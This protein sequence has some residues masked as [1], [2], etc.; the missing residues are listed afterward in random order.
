MA[1]ITR[2]KIRNVY[3]KLIKQPGTPDSVARGVGIGFFI[4]FLIPIG[5]QMVLAFFLAWL[6]KAKKIPAMACT[7]ITNPATVLFIYPIQCYVGVKIL[8]LP[9][10]FAKINDDIKTF[11]DTCSK[12]SFWESMQVSY[13][14]FMN[15][16]G[17]IIASFFVG[18]AIFGIVAAIISYF[19]AYGMIISHR[20]RVEARIT[21]RLAVQAVWK[22]NLE[23]KRSEP[24]TGED[25]NE[26]GKS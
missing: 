19:T 25:K 20:N 2:K 17:D 18:G 9:L 3:L 26:S 8:R 15:L 23:T 5:G 12:A 10:S 7:W 16:G 14:E 21:K 22:T 11:I 13:H 24:G 4:G 1:L 6:L